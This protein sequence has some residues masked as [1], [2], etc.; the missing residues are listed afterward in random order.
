MKSTIKE[1]L[2]VPAHVDRL[3]DLRDFVTRVGKKHGYS[4]RIINAFKLSIDEAATNIIKHAYRDWE[5][6]IVIRSLIKK[7]SL[8][9]ILIDK[10]KY[11][12]PRQVKDPD[13]KKYVDIG[14]KGG[15]GIFMMRRLLDRIDYRKTEN[16]NELWLTKNR[17][18]SK[19]RKISVASIP[20]GLKARY[21]LISMVV[22]SFILLL[23]YLFFFLKQDNIV[24]DQYIENG[25][26]AC[27]VLANDLAKNLTDSNDIGTD[28]ID[29]L[30]NVGS[31]DLL[32]LN[33][34]HTSVNT[35]LKS[36]YSDILLNAIVVDNIQ[37][38]LAIAEEDSFFKVLETFEIP[39]EH[40][41][42]RD[43]VYQYRMK[44]GPEIVDME[45]PVLDDEN[46]KLC[47]VHLFI[48]FKNIKKDITGSRSNVFHLGLLVWI[49]GAA[50]LFLLIYLVM[51]PFRRLQEWVKALGQPGVADELDIDTSTEV[52]EIAKAFSDITMKLR[53]SQAN[54]AEQE[55]L[56]K[57]MQVA[58]EIQQT[59]LPSKFPELEGYDLSAFYEAAKEVGGDYFD[60]V[61][62]DKDTLGIVV[63]DVSGKGVP[64]SLV[65]TMI[66]TALR[67]EARGM[68]DAAEVLTRVNDFVV[69]DMK[70]GMF[71]T[72][73]Y[74]IIDSKRRRINFASAGHNPMILYRA[75]VNKTYYL[76]PRGF[77]IGISLPDKELFKKSLQSDSIA[78]A[79]DD[80]LLVYTDGVTEAMNSKR[81]LFGEERFLKVIRDYG[82][83]K[84]EDF[85][86]NLKKEIISFTEENPQNDDITLVAIKE[87][88]SVEKLEFKRAKE[89]FDLIQ[90]GKNVKEACKK[91]GISTYSYYNKFKT[92]FE[93][94]GVEQY[95]IESPED[96][97]EVK[98]L[99]IEEKTKI[100]DVIKRFPEY[101]AKRISEELNTEHYNFT[102]ISHSRVYEEL[103]QSRLNTKKLR[104]AFVLRGT[105]KKRMKPPGT[106]LLTI[107]GKVI[108]DKPKVIKEVEEVETEAPDTAV[109]VPEEKTK[110]FPKVAEKTK[111]L[112][113]AKKS[114]SE[115]I[116]PVKESVETAKS[117]Q[118]LT[119]VPPEKD[120]D[121]IQVENVFENLGSE[122]KPEPVPE[123]PETD[124]FEEHL[125]TDTFADFIVHDDFDSIQDVE[126]AI[127][128]IE[129]EKKQEKE[130]EKAEIPAEGKDQVEESELQEE[131]TVHLPQSKE[132]KAESSEEPEEKEALDEFEEET[133]QPQLIEINDEDTEKA[134]TPVE[135]GENL[136][137]F[138]DFDFVGADES[139]NL[140]EDE[141]LAVSADIPVLADQNPD[142]DQIFYDF[143]V[144]KN[145]EINQD[146]DKEEQV[147]DDLGLKNEEMRSQN[148]EQEEI[149]LADIMNSE[150][151]I[152]NIPSHDDQDE[153]DEK[154]VED[155]DIISESEKHEKEITISE[156][157]EEF[158]GLEQEK[159]IP[160]KEPET[161]KTEKPVEL[162]K[163][164]YDMSIPYDEIWEIKEME[165]FH[166]FFD[167][168]SFIERDKLSFE[169]LIDLVGGQKRDGRFKEKAVEEEKEPEKPDIN[170]EKDRLFKDK[171]MTKAIKLYEKEN[172]TNAIKIFQELLLKYP[173]DI[174]LHGYIG[175]AYFRNKNYVMA[176]REYEKVLKLEPQNKQAC[177]NLGVVYANQGKLSEAIRQWEK[178]LKMAPE[179]QDI[180]KSIMRAKRYLINN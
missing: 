139:V 76:N 108:V 72:L 63:A 68:K 175:N 97:L 106:P 88:T 113:K 163:E 10:G 24:L 100:Y 57:E 43:N 27:S 123:T 120:E 141:E 166:G 99:S 150:D 23:V 22:F 126:E 165:T 153:I 80:I 58:Q 178:L 83:L 162:I 71:V 167:S 98:H 137:D 67:T 25:G 60:F 79:E 34:A 116:E 142:I 154:N 3:G 172:Y 176:E 37:N 161:P 78:L 6:D 160:L 9:F 92:K 170:K 132:I 136:F 4:E 29:E 1:Q 112:K 81:E 18:E 156:P 38:I 53:D 39:E 47:T 84:A 169:D 69:N 128:K 20:L 62:V 158:L 17:D 109:S 130:E 134:E 70:K 73:F 129:S 51:N 61:E 146:D 145:I 49:I 89:A 82:K 19:R 65:M 48:D 173:D 55:R 168:S 138:A 2:K 16:G 179:R 111:K 77:P 110:T 74:V 102:R 105:K 44:S 107:D 148:I 144:G 5:G 32:V 64:G 122:E 21:W 115:I 101:G 7:N 56:Q 35:L 118:E 91:A 114:E 40:K 54:L 28:V 11:F 119:E 15:L 50:G 147:I 75:S 117:D 85:I 26:K 174:N 103:V 41:K 30:I 12:D 33:K 31:Q 86:D 127:E 42:K 66:R 151:N 121:I 155:I 36:E 171:L 13:L 143:Q 14:K 125:D 149:D 52:G 8:T 157:F 96:D 90:Q 152:I 135:P 95:K 124:T 104:E 131:K 133:V 45:W 94:E 87:Q 93:E 59:L 164:E 140:Q 159:E 177:E 46:R 180:H